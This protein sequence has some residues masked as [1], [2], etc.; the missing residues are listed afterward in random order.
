[1]ARGAGDRAAVAA[2]AAVSRASRRRTWR[3]VRGIAG[4]T[5][6][7]ALAL[8]LAW[9]AGLAWFV[10]RAEQPAPPPGA[11][12]G[13]VALTG[14]ADRVET[15]LR[16]LADGHA[17]VLLLSGIGGN[18]ALAQFARRAGL[19]PA[20]L[21]ARVTLGRTALS[22]HGNARET[23]AWVRDHAV[24]RLIVVTAFYHMPRALIELGRALPGVTLIPDKVMPESLRDGPRDYATLGAMLRL[25]GAEYTKFLATE[26]GVRETAVRLTDWAGGGR[27]E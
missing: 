9:A 18:A 17:P 24:R 21:A 3:R 25:L 16:L 27:P 19:D 11:A 4:R 15:A 10:I 8:A 1:M 6:G 5:I 14:G 20:P 7:L 2:P 26:L 22:T 23:A 13:I 12:D